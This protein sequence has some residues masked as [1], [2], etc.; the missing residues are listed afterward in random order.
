M[1]RKPSAILIHAS[2]FFAPIIVPIIFLLISNN[3]RDIKTLATEGLLFHVIMGILI[4]ISTALMVLLIGIPMVI[5]FG[6]VWIYY[7]IKG[8]L[9]AIKE[10]EFHYPVVNQW[11]R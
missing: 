4:S 11:V 1:E 6:I 8:I 5:A 3:D 2:A 10:E 7:P 9:A